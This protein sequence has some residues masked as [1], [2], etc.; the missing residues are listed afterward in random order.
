MWDVI[1]TMIPT[2]LG[3]GIEWILVLFF[4]VCALVFYAK[5]F[6]L[7]IV[8]SWIINGLLFMWFWAEGLNYVI[9]L[10]LF[11]MFLVIMSLTLYVTS[12]KTQTI[13][14]T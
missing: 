11:F 3:M 8:L 6:M 1:Q 9:P 4:N 7:G 12:Q 10:I 14:I 5:K 13:Q 2:N